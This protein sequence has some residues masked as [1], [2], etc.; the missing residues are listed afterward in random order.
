MVRLGMQG[1]SRGGKEGQKGTETTEWAC[2]LTK[3]I[4]ERQ[5]QRQVKRT[6]RFYSTPNMQQLSIS[7][8]MLEARRAVRGSTRRMRKGRKAWRR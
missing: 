4:A 5:E 7:C 6:E 3:L 8:S 1:D 2:V